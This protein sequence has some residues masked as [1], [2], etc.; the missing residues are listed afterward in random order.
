MHKK[1]CLHKKSA[2]DANLDHVVG[3][4]TT[5][6]YKLNAKEF[7]RAIEDIKDLAERVPSLQPM[8]DDE[9]KTKQFLVLPSI[10]AL[11]Y[12]DANPAEVVPEYTADLG[13][14]QV[15]RPTTL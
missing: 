4:A 8:L 15:G 11:G 7:I 6:I 9:A 14:G 2:A 10:R 5:T 1:S 12:D 13:L 3:A